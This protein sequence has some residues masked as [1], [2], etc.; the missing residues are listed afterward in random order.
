MM[1]VGKS[2]TLNEK[3]HKRFL[4]SAVQAE[5]AVKVSIPHVINVP[6]G[7]LIREHFTNVT[8]ELAK[9]VSNITNAVEY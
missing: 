5:T 9:G 7:V 2:A 4:P 3:L 6:D 1:K 8:K